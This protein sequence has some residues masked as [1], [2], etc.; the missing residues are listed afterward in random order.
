MVREV[1]SLGMEGRERGRRCDSP[2]HPPR[3]DDFFGVVTGA[4]TF[5]VSPLGDPTVRV[6]SNETEKS[7]SEDPSWGNLVGTCV[8]PT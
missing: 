7:G 4:I 2:T 1:C 5:G 8:G 6:G 3:Q